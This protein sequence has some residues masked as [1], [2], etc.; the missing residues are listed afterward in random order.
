MKAIMFIVAEVVFR[1]PG[2]YEIVLV[3]AHLNT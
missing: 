3:L 1:L 2:N